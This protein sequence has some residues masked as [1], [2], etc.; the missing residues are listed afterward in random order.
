M[1]DNIERTRAGFQ[2][3]L[4]GCEKRTLPKSTTRSDDAGQGLLE[5]YRPPSLREERAARAYAAEAPLEV[6]CSSRAA[7]FQ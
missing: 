7:T 3:V 5:F 4:P 1:A 2:I 6:S